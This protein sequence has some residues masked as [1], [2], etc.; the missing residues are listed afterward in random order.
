[1][2]ATDGGRCR[3]LEPDSVYG[4]DH[5][6]LRR[7]ARM[8]ESVRWPMQ[9]VTGRW[10]HSFEED[11]GDVLVYR[12]SDHNFPRS[13]GRDGIEFSADGSCTEWVP[14]RGDALE[15]V[16]GRWRATGD[17]R[18]HVT[19]DRG[20]QRVIEVVQLGPDRLEIRRGAR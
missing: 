12:P 20:E 9:G 8:S 18:L 17:G 11:R 13:P 19:T 6:A 4:A 1:M 14:R 16:P 10:T 2:N 5:L 3:W 15:P 7:R